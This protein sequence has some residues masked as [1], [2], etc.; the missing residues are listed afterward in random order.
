[1]KYLLF[2]FVILTISFSCGNTQENTKEWGILEYSF[3]NGPVSPEYQ[4]SYQIIINKDKSGVLQYS[5]PTSKDLEYRFIISDEQ[6]ETLTGKLNE[7]GIFKGEI[8]ALPNEEIPD[9]GINESV[10]IIF[11][12][13]DP[14]LDQPP[15]VISSPVYPQTSYKINLDRLYSC[16]NELVPKDLKADAESKRLNYIENLK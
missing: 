4:Y 13:P 14:N 8:P 3:W 5:F 16:I 10:K 9:G 11:P 1:M 15:K 7:S 6:L 12:N 2:L